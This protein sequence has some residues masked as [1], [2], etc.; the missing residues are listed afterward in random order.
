MAIEGLPT[1][2]LHHHTEEPHLLRD[3]DDGTYIKCVYESV[4]NGVKTA[5]ARIPCMTMDDLGQYKEG[6]DVLIRFLG[7]HSPKDV[8]RTGFRARMREITQGILL[9]E[10]TDEQVQAM[11][12]KSLPDL[13]KAKELRYPIVRK[14]WEPGSLHIAN[15][16]FDVLE[17]VKNLEI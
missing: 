16:Q 4:A 8:L 17:E 5:D 12:Y 1:L 13:V 11:G 6:N 3:G 9:G 2:W 7:S 15:V 14:L 10:L